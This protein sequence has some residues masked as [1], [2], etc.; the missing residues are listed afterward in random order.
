MQ[1]LQAA[2]FLWPQGDALCFIG[3]LAP[4]GMPAWAA[5]ED[6]HLRSVPNR[7][8]A[9]AAL[10]K[11]TDPAN[12][13]AEAALLHLFL[14]WRWDIGPLRRFIETRGCRLGQDF[15]GRP[16]WLEEYHAELG[17]LSASQYRSLPWS[18]DVFSLIEALPLAQYPTLPGM[19]AGD[20]DGFIRRNRRWLEKHLD[21]PPSVAFPDTLAEDFMQKAV[22]GYLAWRKESPYAG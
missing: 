6:A 16:P 10:A 7:A 15:G 14:D 17:L 3:A 2:Q 19:T 18:K 13:F 20:I 1:H 11:Q 4:D 9:L 8:A 22:A 12:T 21:S 5:K